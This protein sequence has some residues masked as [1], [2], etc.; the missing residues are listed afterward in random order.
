[1]HETSDGQALIKRPGWARIPT[2][3]V[4]ETRRFALRDAKRALDPGLQTALRLV[5]R[6]LDFLS[7][8]LSAP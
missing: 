8:I 5:D 7:F 3:M 4:A 1:M 6:R 2:K